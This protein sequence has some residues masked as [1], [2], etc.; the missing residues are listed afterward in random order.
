M[1]QALFLSAAILLTAGQL[2]SAE[3]VSLDDAIT[4]ALAHDP[5]I[6][7]AQSGVER[8]AAGMD[9]ARAQKGLQ[10]GLRA[11]VGALE[12]D[13]TTDRISQIPRSAGLQA[14]WTVYASGA[15]DAAVDAAN[16]QREAAEKNLLGTR[17]RIVLETF[18]AYARTWLA[19]QTV[20]VAEARAGTFRIRLDETNARLKQGQVTRT[21]TA[22]TEARLA[23]A[24][25]RLE[26]AKAALSA[27]RARLS[28]LTGVANAEPIGPAVMET[29]WLGSEKDVLLEVLRS[30]TDLAAAQ[31]AVMSANSRV[32]QARG[33]FG[34]KVSLRARATT[35]E[36]IY[37]FFEDQISDVG[38]F[39]TV[40]V[41]LFTSGLRSASEREAIAGRSS[42]QASVR[43]V[44]LELEQAV[45]GLWGDIE[46]R[47]LSVE[48]ATRAETAAS[49]AAEGAQKEY[50]AGLR[51][52]VDALDAENAYRDAQI[53][54][55]QAETQLKI[56]EAR[57]LSLSSDL[58]ATL[59]P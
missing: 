38:A 34:P 51:T 48:A 4:L 11:E 9:A 5:A 41:P 21:D 57:L 16:F 58:E 19:E 36:D 40:E 50:E 14:E 27:T 52:L 54:R 44:R 35:G 31:A 10:A 18:E 2:A 43:E 53:A 47:R 1:K 13:F 25:A 56:A 42:A 39:V 55:L 26:A 28:R 8:S 49:L 15:L 20:R 3:P 24:E 59:A 29:A 32:R 46:A 33:E 17:E 6:D 22:L 45:S 30:N 37:F 23:S 12:T 7:R